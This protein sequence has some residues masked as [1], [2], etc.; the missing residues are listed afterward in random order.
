MWL[1]KASHLM[2]VFI[3]V[4]A[5]REDMCAWMVW[6]RWGS[7]GRRAPSGLRG[8]PPLLL[9]DMV[10]GSSWGLWVTL[11]SS[12]EALGA[13][14]ELWAALGD[15]G[16][17][18]GSSGGAPGDFGALGG[19]RGGSGGLRRGVGGSGDLWSAPARLLELW[20]L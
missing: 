6:A 17:L 16:E 7:R 13:S 20:E 1:N 18:W 11:G 8:G 19:A 3:C 5:A 4:A 2:H 15:S 14:G 10:V 12:V 9:W